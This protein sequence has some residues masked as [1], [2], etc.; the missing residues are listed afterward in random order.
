MQQHFCTAE[1]ERSSV[2]MTWQNAIGNYSAELCLRGCLPFHLPWLVIEALQ[3]L[4]WCLALDSWWW[5]ANWIG[6]V[7]MWSEC[8]AV[9]MCCSCVVLRWKV[10]GTKKRKWLRKYCSCQ[11]SV[12][13]NNRREQKDELWNVLDK[14]GPNRG[15]SG[16]KREVSMFTKFLR[17]GQQYTFL[18]VNAVSYYHSTVHNL[19]PLA[20]FILYIDGFSLALNTMEALTLDYIT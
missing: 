11:R 7:G 17:T 13:T 19:E 16:S 15:R 6:M 14:D 1:L 9:G 8:D 3:W 2:Q 4:L 18:I 10:V 5:H 12:E 20:S